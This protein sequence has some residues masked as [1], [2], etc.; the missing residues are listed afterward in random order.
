MCSRFPPRKC[1]RA[2][3]ATR[4]NP[5]WTS[6]GAID[7]YFFPIHFFFPSKC[8]YR[9]AI[10]YTGSGQWSSWNLIWPDIFVAG[11]W[12][13]ACLVFAISII[14]ASVSDSWFAPADLV[15][16]AF[17]ESLMRDQSAQI[18][19]KGTIHTLHRFILFYKQKAKVSKIFFLMKY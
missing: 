14:Y 1:R 16:P 7:R 9:T 17:P 6:A 10:S 18:W 15:W 19:S 11:Q 3:M 8:R 2:T 4:A 5:W 13:G 12:N